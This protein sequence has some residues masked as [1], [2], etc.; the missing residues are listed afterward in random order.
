M[1]ND[2]GTYPDPVTQHASRLSRL[3]APLID[4][5]PSWI[6]RPANFRQ[7]GPFSVHFCYGDEGR[8]TIEIDGR[9]LLVGN[10]VRDPSTEQAGRYR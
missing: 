7:L 3:L 6:W 1:T 2:G 4:V 10:R 8:R 9:E 5:A